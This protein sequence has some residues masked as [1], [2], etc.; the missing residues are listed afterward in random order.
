MTSPS[1]DRA[2]ILFFG[3]GPKQSA[4]HILKKDKGESRK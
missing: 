2:G 1:P 3:I 4:G